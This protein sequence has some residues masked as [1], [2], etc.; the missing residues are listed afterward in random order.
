MASHNRLQFKFSPEQIKSVEDSLP[1]PV[2][3]RRRRLLPRVLLEWGQT[4]HAKLLL[5]LSEP[6][7]TQ[8]DRIQKQKDATQLACEL[9]RAFDC[10]ESAWLVAKLFRTEG[11]TPEETSRAEWANMRRRLNEFRDFLAKIASPES[12]KSFGKGAPRK[13]VPYLVLQDAA[14]IFEWYTGDKAARA[15]HSLSG[16][17]S[18]RFH[19]FVSVLWP[20]ILGR[21]REGLSNAMKN[22]AAWPS[23]F[24]E[25]STSALIANM[26]LRHPA[27]ELFK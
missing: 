15:V 13:V 4:D 18:S 6:R 26:D 12:A 24:D 16:K 7:Q 25:F 19:Q 5:R 14:A 23:R 8:R 20:I 27:W 17:E 11:R 1:E 21:G 10:L 9:L 2:C 3:E 22:W